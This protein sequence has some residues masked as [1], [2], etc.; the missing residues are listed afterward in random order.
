MVG[1]DLP[2]GDSSL[3]QCSRSARH[4]DAIFDHVR[5]AAG[6]AHVVFEDVEAAVHAAHQ[7]YSRDGDEVAQRRLDAHCG[8]AELRA[9][10]NQVAWDDAVGQ[11]ATVAINVGE[12]RVER[13]HPLNQARLECG[14]GGCVDDPRNRVEREDALGS[15]SGAVHIEGHAHPA[16]HAVSARANLGELRRPHREQRIDDARAAGS[17]LARKIHHLVE[18]ARVDLVRRPNGH[19]LAC[20]G[21]SRIHRRSPYR[22]DWRV[23]QHRQQ[24]R[25]L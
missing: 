8:A 7:I 10:E 6:R 2:E 25:C 12:K 3:R 24:R 11:D 18:N 15:V 22:A 4:Y 14:P 23:I 19:R 5:N 13:A 1:F 21:N 17:R 20:F 9:S 16:E